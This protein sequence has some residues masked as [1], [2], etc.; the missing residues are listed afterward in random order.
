[1]IQTLN[2]NIEPTLPLSDQEN[3]LFALYCDKC[4]LD[5]VLAYTLKR[6]PKDKKK[7]RKEIKSQLET[8]YKFTDEERAIIREIENRLVVLMSSDIMREDL[9]LT[10]LNSFMSVQ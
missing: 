2:D 4:N 1:M 8:L 7:L 6:L 5:R 10:P 3:L 9:D